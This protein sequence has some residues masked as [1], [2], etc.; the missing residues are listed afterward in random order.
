MTTARH[1]NG[2]LEFQFPDIRPDWHP[3]GCR[4]YLNFYNVKYNKT[5]IRLDNIVPQ[6]RRYI[7]LA[8]QY[9]EPSLAAIVSNPEYASLPFKEPLI[10]VVKPKQSVKTQSGATQRTPAVPNH[11][12]NLWSRNITHASRKC[13]IKL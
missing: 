13:C 8:Q 6:L 7:Y 11:D 4:R 5:S 2:F 9:S 10:Q 3:L 1:V 12:I